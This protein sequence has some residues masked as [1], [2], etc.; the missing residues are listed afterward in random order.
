M[1]SVRPSQCY[2]Q[3]CSDEVPNYHLHNRKA[4]IAHRETLRHCTTTSSWSPLIVARY[5]N[6]LKQVTFGVTQPKDIHSTSDA[7]RDLGGDGDNNKCYCQRSPP[8]HWHIL[9]NSK[10]LEECCSEKHEE[11]GEKQSKE[12][13]GNTWH[14]QEW[15]E[16]LLASPTLHTLG[17]VCITI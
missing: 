6:S 1:R 14:Y 16:V 2:P 8:W 3:D 15:K 5:D 12:D 9:Q 13:S 17:V 4:S 10:V 11:R 7:Y